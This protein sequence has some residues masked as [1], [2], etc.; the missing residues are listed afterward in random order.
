MKD[1]FKTPDMGITPVFYGLAESGTMVLRGGPGFTRYGSL[2]PPIH[3]GVLRK[4]RL[5]Y[6]FRQLGALLKG[7]GSLPAKPG[8]WM[9]FITGPSRT[10]DIEA[11]L[12]VH[13]PRETHLIL[14]G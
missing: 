5:V 8:D 7:R 6:D 12:G 4:D 2:L 1:N 9:V 10:G 13:G 11:T 3:I 14:F